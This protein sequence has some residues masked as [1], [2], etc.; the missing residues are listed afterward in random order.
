MERL[1]GIRIPSVPPAATRPKAKR[2]PQLPEKMPPAFPP[3]G[4]AKP[5]NSF[6][7]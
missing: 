2:D 5:G 1:G 7:Q 3:P 4:K 6:F